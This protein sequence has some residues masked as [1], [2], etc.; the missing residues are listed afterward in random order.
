MESILSTEMTV[1][2]VTCRWF[3]SCSQQQDNLLKITETNIHTRLQ[4]LGLKNV[5]NSCYENVTRHCL[6]NKELIQALLDSTTAVIFRRF[7]S[8]PNLLA[9]ASVSVDSDEE[10]YVSKVRCFSTKTLK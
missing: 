9:L 5:D 2:S 7:S 8:N 10:N 3:D 6:L 1:A 4:P